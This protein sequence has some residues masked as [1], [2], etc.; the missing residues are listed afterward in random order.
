MASLVPGARIANRYVLDRRVGHGGHAQIWTATDEADGARVALKFLHPDSCSPQRAWTVLQHESRMAAALDHPGVLRTGTPQQDGDT[1]FLPLEYA[2]GADLNSLRGASYVRVVPIL[3][4]VADILDHAHRHGIAHRDVKPGN[5]LVD[6]S[7]AARL[8]DFGTASG[9]G[10]SSGVAPGSPFTSS[11]QQ[12]CGEPATVADDVYGLGATAYELLGGYPPDYPEF[13]LG[14]ALTRMPAT[15]RPQQPAPPRLVR[16]VMQMLARVPSDRPA[17]MRQ[18][19]EELR[20]C[21]ADT[22]S[23]E[24]GAALIEEAKPASPPPAARG[25][26]LRWAGAIAA[27]LAAASAVLWLGLRP[28]RAPEAVIG[29]PQLERFAAPGEAIAPAA[30]VALAGASRGI[31]ESVAAERA[32]FEA[33]LAAA[34]D[35]VARGQPAVARLAL[36]RAARLRADT[37]EVQAGLK[38]VERL[39]QAIALHSEGL[40]AETAGDRQRAVARFDAALSLDPAFKPAR[41]SRDRVTA[42]QR[43]RVEA[44]QAEA[45]RRE[46]L[47]ADERDER[48]GRELE[49]AERWGD[50]VTLYEA[51]LDRDSSLPFAQQ[52]LSRAR[53]RAA[54][55]ARL[56]D[57]IDRPARLGTPDVRREA[58]RAMDRARAVQPATARLS[59]QLA[60]LDELVTGFGVDTR[61]QITSDNSTRV[62]I[63]R[64]GDLGTF[65]SRELVLRPGSYTVIGT[66]EGYR[67][68]RRELRIEPGQ[69]SAA[70]SVE[71]TERI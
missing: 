13:D 26:R 9:L 8:V 19:A 29:R 62:S 35:A 65:S 28:E 30:E 20:Q 69:R 59:A 58:I 6:A 33:E 27:A 66:R 15:L 70:L 18:V 71:C 40:Q 36:D 61:V 32:G 38:S 34:R 60:R 2:G 51:V 50:A 52:G 49:D 1:V 55:D 48:V 41:E 16:L 63:N 21:L 43:R 68:V 12:L 25:G 67:D 54:L 10:G 3:L 45:A 53:E 37:P 11:P 22:L 56:Q 64:V 5:V 57:Y 14:R 23:V 42:E 46:R 24:E 17:D 44:A 31:E 39:E 4:E 47:A 7:G